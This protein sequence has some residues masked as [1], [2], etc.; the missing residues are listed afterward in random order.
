MSLQKSCHNASVLFLGVNM[1]QNAA[2][3]TYLRFSIESAYSI[4]SRSVACSAIQT[5]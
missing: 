5:V 2:M 4:H 1:T 3:C